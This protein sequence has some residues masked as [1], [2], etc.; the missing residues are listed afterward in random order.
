M[1]I[2]RSF[3]CPDCAHTLDVTLA[4]EDAD[5]PAP[6]CPFCAERMNQEFKPFAIGGSH[7]ARAERLT[8]DILEKDYHVADLQ[9]DQR[10]E[11]T[12][13]R[14]RYADQSGPVGR[15]SWGAIQADIAGA[16]RMGRRNRLHHGSG[17]DILHSNLKKGVERDLIADSKRRA[18]KVW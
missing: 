18:M 14:V 9:R 12:P 1:P 11:S 7:R 8:E 10:P 6:A 17:L 13:A 16:V 4:L 15:S 5:A 2:V 3:M